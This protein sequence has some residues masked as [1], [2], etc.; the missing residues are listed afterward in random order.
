MLKMETLR[1]LKR[2]GRA[3]MLA[4]IM[5]D[6]NSKWTE[7]HPETIR[8]YLLEFKE[9]N[10]VEKDENGWYLTA[11]GGEVLNVAEEITAYGYLSPKKL[12]QGTYYAK[13]A[14]DVGILKRW[15]GT[16]SAVIPGCG[17]IPTTLAASGIACSCGE[18]V[19]TVDQEQVHCTRCGRAYAKQYRVN[20][21]ELVKDSI[22]YGLVGGG[23]TWSK[24]GAVAGVA[25][26]ILK[27]I[28][29]PDVEYTTYQTPLYRPSD[30]PNDLLWT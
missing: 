11:V 4:E 13:L 27:N 21:S 2:G 3:L 22:V 29:K 14:L 19:P 18:F 7:I 24:K 17:G 30:P 8:R 25:V 26:A 12:P 5:K 16:I 1:A 6:I 23:I 9:E 15:H 20:L 28:A 10:L